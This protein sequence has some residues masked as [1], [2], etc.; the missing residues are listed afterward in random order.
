MLSIMGDAHA[1]AVR[2]NNARTNAATDF[3]EHPSI[4]HTSSKSSWN[5]EH[6]TPAGH[7]IPARSRQHAANWR[8]E[9]TSLS[10]SGLYHAG[11]LIASAFKN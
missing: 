10:L 3:F 8:I 7:V 6:P 1:L 9:R 4:A 5:Q 11:Q 2:T